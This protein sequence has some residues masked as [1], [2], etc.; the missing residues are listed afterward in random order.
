MPEDKI[1][2]PLK[3]RGLEQQLELAHN[4]VGGLTSA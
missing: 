2:V 3:C 4:M 1:L